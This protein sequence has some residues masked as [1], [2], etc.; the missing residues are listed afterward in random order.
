[1]ANDTPRVALITGAARRLGRASA[2]AL[3]ARGLNVIIHYRHSADEAMALVEA[4]NAQRHNSAYAL[5]ADLD[6]PDA[7]RT[8]AREA[9]AVDG[10]ID[11]LV[12]NASSFYATPLANANDDDWTRLLHSNLRAPFILT[13]ALADSL[14]THHGSIVNLIDVY[15]QKPLFEHSLYCMAKAGL[16]SLTL[17]AA[18]EL[19]PHVRVNGVAPGPILW[20]EQGQD[21]QDDI[22]QATA[23]KRTGTPADI[24]NAVTWLALDAPF[25][26]GQI[27]AVDGGR[28]LAFMGG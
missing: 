3:H 12:N 15:A 24:A 16:A 23:L 21:N 18:R 22:V 5:C 13:Q 10:R 17:S 28:S 19:G 6:D 27:I 1:M 26:T 25:V 8:L 11:V 7:V 4:L 2:E 20:P 14:T 9:L